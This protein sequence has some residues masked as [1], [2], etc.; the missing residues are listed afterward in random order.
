MEMVSTA[1][2]RKMVG[3]LNAAKPYK[4]KLLKMMATLGKESESISS[5][6]FPYSQRLP[7]HALLVLSA[8]RGLCGAYNTNVLRLAH[9]RYE[10]LSS[11]NLSCDVYIDWQ[12]G[13]F[14][15]QVSK[16][17]CKRKLCAY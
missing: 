4:D 14:L 17:T 1:K 7:K 16:Y 5:P 13:K 6:Y 15:F 8:N 11:Q 3:R 10:E 9:Q 2:S 12:K